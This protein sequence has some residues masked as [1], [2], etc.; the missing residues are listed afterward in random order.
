MN[1]I[2]SLSE[3]RFEEKPSKKE[4]SQLQ[5]T[6][7]R[8]SVLDLIAYIE[9]GQ[10]FLCSTFSN[11]HRLTANF[12]A[13]Q[14]I[15]V[16]FDNALS[17]TEATSILTHYGLSYSF[18]YYTLSHT[19][20]APRFRLVFILD[21]EIR[22]KELVVDI[23]KALYRFFDK[24]SDRSCTDVTRLWLGSSR[25][26]FFGDSLQPMS[27]I[28]F[29]DKINLKKYV[30]DKNQY[31]SCIDINTIKV[32][33]CADTV[34]PIIYTY[35]NNHISTK[36]ESITS[37]P[38][39]N[40]PPIDNWEMKALLSYELFKRFYHGEGSGKESKLSHNELFGL[41]T[42]LYPLCGG[43]KLFKD[44]LQKNKLYSKDKFSIMP[45]V[46]YR[47]FL[48]QHF[49]EFSP[50]EVDVN[51]PHQTFPQ[52]LKKRGKITITEQPKLLTLGEAEKELADAFQRITSSKDNMIYLLVCAPGLG[53]S[54]YIKNLQNVVVAFPDHKLKEE[55]FH[56]SKLPEEHKLM[57]PNIKGRFSPSIER[58]FEALYAM[59]LP[60]NVMMQL[61]VLAE[62][63]IITSEQTQKDVTAAKEF[64]NQLDEAVC[65]FGNKTIFTTHSRALHV[66]WLHDTIIYDEDPINSI[67]EKHVATKEEMETLLGC[68]LIKG[69]KVKK[70]AKL[71]DQK[72]FE[73]PKA[74]PKL[75]IKQKLIQQICADRRF[76]SNVLNFF[77]SNSYFIDNGHIHY[78]INH[79]DKF[80]EH[81]KYIICDATASVEVY[82]GLFGNRLEVIDIANV[83]FKGMLNQHTSRS[84]SKSGFDAYGTSLS[85]DTTL[86]TITF[87]DQK[88]NIPNAAEDMHFGRVRGSNT[89]TGKNLNV[90][91]T[92][93]Y[94]NNYYKFL[95]DA[96]GIENHD[97]QTHH[98]DVSY[99]GREFRFKTF[100]HPVLQKLH[101]ETV[102][103]ELVQAVHRARLL[104]YDCTVNL[105]SN[106]PL[107]QAIYLY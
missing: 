49:K 62:D 87:K 84:Y 3:R 25:K 102:E 45:Y 72:E 74:T 93:H 41:A 65:S 50:F 29:I 26:C 9:Q 70:L 7:V 38:I 53:K 92:Y 95:A 63:G 82:R 30:G 103:G 55:Q 101:L 24:K 78:C 4:I 20:A 76:K 58:Y 83:E 77:R 13:Q 68:L 6:G 94:H 90:V 18:G 2:F 39:I 79:K 96:L 86:P 106:F 91:G 81:K 10:T 51:N 32:E 98:L 97:W 57:T 14:L 16:D 48:P 73:T 40:T 22:D 107:L 52:A 75:K 105:Y 88:G 42:N 33:K 80:K 47:E 5:F 19:E 44:L 60:R 11:N 56:T 21:G 17:L 85:I 35:S 54:E 31:R 66:G 46:K 64:Q 37:I 99:K 71:L 1:I 69:V 59:N 15:A 27:L 36:D 100:S 8:R 61:R 89:L 67:L 28:G 12:I 34:N 104:R 23:N 43:E